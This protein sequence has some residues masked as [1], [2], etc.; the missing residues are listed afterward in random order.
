MVIDAEQAC[1]TP[2]GVQATGS[3]TMTSA[4]LGLLRSDSRSRSEFLP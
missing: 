2:R 4:Q 3:T 1:V